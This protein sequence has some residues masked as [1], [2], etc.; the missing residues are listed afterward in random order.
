MA[1]LIKVKGDGAK[2]YPPRGKIL[3]TTVSLAGQVNVFEALSGWLNKEVEVV[4]ENAR[5]NHG[6]LCSSA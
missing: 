1:E 6:L 4:P 3:F 5:T 2:I